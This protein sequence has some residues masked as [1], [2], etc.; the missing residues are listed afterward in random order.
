M[1]V[2]QL[3]TSARAFGPEFSVEHGFYRVSLAWMPLAPSGGFYTGLEVGIEEYH[4]CVRP[5]RTT[6]KNLPGVTI[7]RDLAVI[8]N[9][10]AFLISV[11]PALRRQHN[12]F[13]WYRMN[14]TALEVSFTIAE[15]EVNVALNVTVRE[16]LASRCTGALL[17]IT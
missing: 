2:T 12:G 17:R 8:K 14:F 15:Y 9:E 4:G 6:E 7:S 13:V 16:I 1:T 10:T 11:V 3:D 5:P